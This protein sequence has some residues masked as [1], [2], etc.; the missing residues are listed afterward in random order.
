MYTFLLCEIRLI[1]YLLHLSR[2]VVYVTVDRSV[3]WLK[4]MVNRFTACLTLAVLYFCNNFTPASSLMN[5]DFVI[6]SLFSLERLPIAFW[7]Q[8]SLFPEDSPIA[9][10]VA[11]WL[12]SPWGC[13]AFSP[14]KQVVLMLIEKDHKTQCLWA[15]RVTTIVLISRNWGKAGGGKWKVPSKDFLHHHTG[16]GSHSGQWN[17]FYWMA[18][19]NFRSFGASPKRVM[20]AQL[21]PTPSVCRGVLNFTGRKYGLAHYPLVPRC[22]SYYQG[23]YFHIT[24]IFVHVVD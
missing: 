15:A 14:L 10:M 11:W 20:C 24:W 13:W 5:C 19:W 4:Y 18:R 1:F 3:T 2:H 12:V 8:L 9:F 21:W 17:S 23:F 22:C 7:S 16:F 6:A